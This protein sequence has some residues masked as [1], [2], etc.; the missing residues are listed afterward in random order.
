V[1]LAVDLAQLRAF[2][3]VAEELHFGRAA[4]RL[5]VV[6]SAV[7]QHVS[8][9]ERE[10]GGR[11][12]DRTSRRVELTAAGRTLLREARSVLGAVQQARD[13]TSLAIRASRGALSLASP[14]SSRDEAALP[15]LLA[16]EASS[17]RAVVDLVELPSREVCRRVASGEVD[18]GFAWLPEVPDTVATRTVAWRRLTVVLPD[19]HDLRTKDEISPGDLVGSR[20]VV[21]RRSDNPRLHDVVAQALAEPDLA[22]QVDSLDTMTAL[23]RAGHGVGI[24]IADACT[25]PRAGVE[26]M[27]AVP[28]A[29]P[30]VPLSLVWCRDNT[31]PALPRFL[32]TVSS[33]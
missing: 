21:G 29:A 27:A 33:A 3:A 28:L 32:A 10:L 6:P 14:A 16:F 15:A 18:A 13:E 9:L 22:R 30:P 5:H 1:D 20:F 19:D 24:T 26:G 17:P 7:S 12:F 2:V 8:R 25:V 23:V 11:L 4:E 31:N